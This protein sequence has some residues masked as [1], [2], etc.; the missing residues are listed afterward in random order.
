MKSEE[1]AAVP[2]RAKEGFP[3]RDV[4][5]SGQD[6]MTARN[7]NEPRAESEA[8]A[9]SPIQANE[10]AQSDATN[11]REPEQVKRSKTP[12][13][14][15][16]GEDRRQEMTKATNSGSLGAG[17][18]LNQFSI[19]IV[20]GDFS[21]AAMGGKSGPDIRREDKSV[22]DPT[23]PFAVF[24]SKRLRETQAQVRHWQG[25]LLE[26]RLLLVSGAD[27]DI[28]HG[29][30]NELVK[31]PL[32]QRFELREWVER[33]QGPEALSFEFFRGTFG[34]GG[35]VL[36]AMRL[37][38]DSPFLDSVL[39]AGLETVMALLE[40]NDV[41]MILKLESAS[42]IL[43]SDCARFPHW[44]LDFLRYALDWI[45]TD[46]EEAAKLANALKR[47]R[48]EGKWGRPLTDTDFKHQI[49]EI[50]L[51]EEGADGLRRKVEALDAGAAETRCEGAKAPFTPGAAGNPELPAIA[52][53]A[54]ATPM[55]ASYDKLGKAILFTATFFPRL[56][57]E[58]FERALRTVAG[59]ETMNVIEERQQS[60]PGASADDPPR[61]VI[62]K[63]TKSTTLVQL[64]SQD[65]DRHLQKCHL[66][67]L[68]L[69]TGER[70]V[71]FIT[72]ARAQ[73]QQ[74]FEYGQAFYTLHCRR[75][76]L[77]SAWFF[78]EDLSEQ[79]L[80]DLLAV[81]TSA[82]AA[83]PGTYGK[84][85]LMGATRGMV[86]YLSDT[87][88]EGQ[89]EL[90]G[91][92]AA[93]MEHGLESAEDFAELLRVTF[94]NREF[95]SKV[96]ADR[97]RHIELRLSQLCRRM[98][99]EP[100]LG[101]CVNEY[102]EEL[103]GQEQYEIVLGL[104]QNLRDVP[105]FD[106]WSWLRRI[107]NTGVP[108]RWSSGES[109]AWLHEKRAHRAL[110]ARAMVQEWMDRELGQGNLPAY[111]LLEVVKGW[112]PPAGKEPAEFSMAE[113]YALAFLQRFAEKTDRTWETWEKE[114]YDQAVS[115]PLLAR[116]GLEKDPPNELATIEVDMLTTW[117]SHKGLSYAARIHWL[118]HLTG[119][120]QKG[121]PYRS[122]LLDDLRNALPAETEPPGNDDVP[123]WEEK[124]REMAQ[125]TDDED[126][127]AFQISD[128]LAHWTMT[129]LP[130]MGEPASQSLACWQNLLDGVALGLQARKKL[131]QKIDRTWGV[132]SEAILKRVSTLSLTKE[133]KAERTRGKALRSLLLRLRRQFQSARNS[134]AVSAP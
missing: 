71:E 77:N 47:Q 12:A 29:A 103:L 14:S 57:L 40:E 53:S 63:E 131:L 106:Y 98:L 73:L 120:I 83:A 48:M 17:A 20:Q 123:G 101:K 81:S 102:F 66:R 25:K 75:R 30:T 65:Q 3:P 52:A 1:I 116:W 76:I 82:A 55:L 109:E 110:E 2:V 121:R 39:R 7:E 8:R 44:Q 93:R 46:A 124:L 58:E 107:L 99:E 15:G 74:E 21:M 38:Q 26:K 61:V 13:A 70:V 43:L 87:N 28:L 85:L 72:P 36:L 27:A 127:A 104:G 88:Q 45:I 100:A 130:L 122:Y 111:R 134:L 67:P 84:E 115:N 117:L 92:I 132:L 18:I 54:S 31:H 113:C 56:S 129:A 69:P 95:W 5:S 60:Y 34:K 128:F 105:T 49:E 37:A 114:K 9:A 50:L 4:A 96:A 119:R 32:C 51:S 11:D 68:S 125:A 86:E 22:S 91:K 24:E 33:N 79:A 94:E 16:A 10:P 41:M 126:F 64:W 78:E 19:G 80:Q 89:A 118:D 97:R 59:N 112:L 108:A 23:V 90:A 6:E 42:R 133:T 35:P 62:H